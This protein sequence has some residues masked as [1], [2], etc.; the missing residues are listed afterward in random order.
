MVR[1]L[2]GQ[3][4]PNPSALFPSLRALRAIGLLATTIYYAYYYCY[5]ENYKH[6]NLL[7]QLN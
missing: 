7:V 4:R 2:S 1:S 3:T 6:Q 5:T